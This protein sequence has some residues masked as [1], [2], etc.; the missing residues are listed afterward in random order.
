MINPQ[1]DPTHDPRRDP[2]NSSHEDAETRHQPRHDE[3]SPP[4]Q[5][6][7]EDDAARDLQARRRQRQ[8]E[9]RKEKRQA[10][11]R[12]DRVRRDGNS[13]QN[14]SPERVPPE[15][16]AL[17]K[18]GER[19]APIPGA[20]AYYATTGGDVISCVYRKPRVLKPWTNSRGYLQVDLVPADREPGSKR[21]WKPTVHKVVKLT[22]DGPLPVDPAAPH[23]AYDVC[24]NDGDKENNALDNLRYDLKD[25]NGR[26]SL[27]HG[28]RKGK[29]PGTGLTPVAVWELRCR[30]VVEPVP[31]LYA[32]YVEAYGVTEATVRVALRGKRAW[33]WVPFP[34][35]AP[36]VAE[37]AQALGIY[38][39]DA[40]GLLALARPR[41]QGDDGR[42]GE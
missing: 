32:E 19:A 13:D 16:L 2:M 27:R 36:T 35:D 20:G 11:L 8:K 1:Q 4:P 18:E 21:V 3:P 25:E 31:A 28:L 38:E 17:L 7:T 33:G 42:E 40:A 14:P 30:A 41:G 23:A 9:R 39:E 24:H 37:L 26:D 29:R 15:V 34:E 6:D 10:P 12:H 22:F 5:E